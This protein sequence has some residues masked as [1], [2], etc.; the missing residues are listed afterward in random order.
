MSPSNSCLVDRADSIYIYMFSKTSKRKERGHL[1]H[2]SHSIYSICMIKECLKQYYF[3]STAFEPPNEEK[4]IE[5]QYAVLTDY[6][7]DIFNLSSHF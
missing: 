7:L 2:F 1:N 6:A 4:V 3:G 5:T